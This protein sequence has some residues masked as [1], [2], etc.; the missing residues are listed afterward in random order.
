[1]GVRVQSASKEGSRGWGLEWCHAA[2]HL[3]HL[4]R[5]VARVERLALGTLAQRVPLLE[6]QG[7]SGLRLYVRTS[8]GR[9][10]AM[11]HL[12]S[13][14]YLLP[15]RALRAPS[16]CPRAE[17]P[18]GPPEL[19]LPPWLHPAPWLHLAIHLAIHLAVAC[20]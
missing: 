5:A 12:Y 20:E 8:G 7:K 1:M 11:C 4:A 10:W 19:H 17:T 2:R 9:A 16:L 15:P 3:G 13:G 18:M 6:D 14:G